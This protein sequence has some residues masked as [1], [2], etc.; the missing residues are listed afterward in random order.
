M[1]RFIVIYI[2]SILLLPYSFG[3]VTVRRVDSVSQSAFASAASVT[4]THFQPS[5]DSCP[6]NVLIVTCGNDASTFSKMTYGGI[7]LTQRAHLTSTETMDIWTLT[8]ST[9]TGNN[10]I[11]VTNGASV[12]VI[13]GAVTFCGVSLATPVDATATAQA[14]GTNPSLAV[15]IISSGSYAIVG[16]FNNGTSFTDTPRSSVN[17]I[18]SLFNNGGPSTL[19]AYIDGPFQAGSTTMA[20]TEPT[21]GAWTKAIMSIKPS[22]GT[23]I[24][25][26]KPP[27]SATSSSMVGN[28]ILLS[29]SSFVVSS[30]G[31]CIST[32]PNSILSDTCVAG[33]GSPFSVNLTGL[34]PNTL[35]YVSAY[36]TNS[37]GTDYGVTIPQVTGTKILISASP[38]SGNSKIM[39]GN[40][41]ISIR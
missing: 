28:G 26:T 31:V 13:C 19:A 40:G 4:W 16:I 35:Y 21:S 22:T 29:S 24:I 32:H 27:T 8:N 20:F 30:F 18:Q 3:A 23:P 17:T 39:P 6:N 15:T 5:L 38:G 10:S 36:A 1:N 14:T 41:T 12:N 25:I 34:T 37:E 33:S 2:L 9:M 7:P 11:I